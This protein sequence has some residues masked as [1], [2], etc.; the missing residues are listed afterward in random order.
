MGAFRLKDIFWTDFGNFLVT[1]GRAFGAKGGP[2]NSQN[3]PQVSPQR[4]PETF[5]GVKTDARN[6]ET[7][8]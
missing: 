3:G 6:G 2:M 1:L 8:L 5:L 7:Y 4:L